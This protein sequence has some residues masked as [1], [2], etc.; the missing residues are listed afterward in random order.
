MQ[1]LKLKI[2][3]NTNINM[4]MC[5]VILIFTK[6]LYSELKTYIYICVFVYT[7]DCNLENAL[8]NIHGE[9]MNQNADSDCQSLRL[10]II[11][12]VFSSKVFVIHF[13]YIFN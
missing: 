2:L 8:K 1:P 12:V 11:I 4:K 10:Y 6:K 3:K 7:F 9:K 13:V 5:D